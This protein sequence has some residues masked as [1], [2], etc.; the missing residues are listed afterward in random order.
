MFDIGEKNLAAL[1]F[2]I[3]NQSDSNPTCQ[4]DSI[5]HWKIFHFKI[6][7]A[8]WTVICATPMGSCLRYVNGLPGWD[9]DGV[10]RWE[11][12]IVSDIF[13]LLGAEV[14]NWGLAL[15]NMKPVDSYRPQADPIGVGRREIEIVSAFLFGLH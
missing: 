8:A 2:W 10:G 4:L 1:F 6:V 14:F 7:V 12:E 9:P 3:V 11:G 13:L 15:E 5:S